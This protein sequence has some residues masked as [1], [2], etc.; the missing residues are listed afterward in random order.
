MINASIYETSFSSIFTEKYQRAVLEM[1]FLPQRRPPDQNHK[2][3]TGTLFCFLLQ[4]VLYK[5]T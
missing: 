4:Q 2:C 1:L 3:F 5:E